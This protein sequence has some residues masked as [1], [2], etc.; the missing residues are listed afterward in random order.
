[1]KRPLHLVLLATL[2]LTFTPSTSLAGGG[3]HGACWSSSCSGKAAVRTFLMPHSGHASN[4]AVTFDLTLEE[5][6]RLYTVGNL[7]TVYAQTTDEA[8]QEGY[9]YDM[10]VGETDLSAS[11]D[12]ALPEI[13]FDGSYTLRITD[14]TQTRFGADFAHATHALVEEYEE[15]D[16]DAGYYYAEYYVVDADGIYQVGA[17]EVEGDGTTHSYNEAKSAETIRATFPLDETMGLDKITVDFDD[18]YDQDIQTRQ[19]VEMHG[20]GML[21]LGAQFGGEQV[22]AGAFINDVGYQEPGETDAN[23]VIDFETVYSIFGED[24]TY[25]SFNVAIPDCD[26]DDGCDVAFKGEIEIINI[27]LWRV[28]PASSVAADY[29]TTPTGLTL[30]SAMP[31]PVQGTARVGYTLPANADV[32][33]SVYDLL[34]RKVATLASGAKA[35]GDHQAR[36]DADLAPGVYVM[37]LQAGGAQ[38]TRRVVVGR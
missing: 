29:G 30:S 19:I 8:Y 35:A 37:R 10:N 1:M 26:S 14:P 38:V 27:E 36:L 11:F 3:G 5:F 33:L 15:G 4:A 25:L 7:I 31:H 23:E 34:G 21:D 2:A 20:F 16:Y 17:V 6:T 24:G 9:V 13:D 28:A 32:D 12:Y 22:S 18:D